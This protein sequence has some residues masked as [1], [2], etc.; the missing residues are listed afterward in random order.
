FETDQGRRMDGKEIIESLRNRVR[1][2]PFADLEGLISTASLEENI[3]AIEAMRIQ[4]GRIKPDAVLSVQRGGAFLAEVL[5]SGVD[6]FPPSVSV[7]KHVVQQPGQ[8]DLV[9][10]TPHLEAE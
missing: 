10:R 9:Q 8:E 2:A 1:K 5:G 3:L 6:G 4:I 7:S